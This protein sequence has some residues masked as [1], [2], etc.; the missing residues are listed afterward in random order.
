MRDYTQLNRGA[1]QLGTTVGGGNSI[2][3]QSY[4]DTMA[5]LMANSAREAQTRKNNSDAALNEQRLQNMRS[6][7]DTFLRNATGLNE[8]QY[9][10]LI[11]G[12]RHGW[13][14]KQAEG[15]PTPDGTYPTMEDRPAWATPD[16]INRY[17]TGEMALSAND[18]GTGKTS[19]EQLMGA[20]QDAVNLNRQDAIIN[21]QVDPDKVAA[22]MAAVAGKPTMDVTSSGIA[23]KPYGGT[24][25]INSTAFDRANE[26]K[27]QNKADR[28]RSLT[29][30]QQANNDEIDAARKAI[31]NLSREDVIKRTQQYTATGRENPN[32]DPYLASMVRKATQRKVGND[33]E[34]ESVYQTFFGKG[35]DHADDQ[36]P[37]PDAK[38]APD[39]NWY[40]PDPNRPGK[41]VRVRRVQED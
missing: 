35:S 10:Q 20:M 24:K 27:L 39:G 31:A 14:L 32:Y 5:K 9:D 18:V 26:I 7:R 2:E 30:A 38:K 28:A 11:N 29:P 17:R 40:I 6:G 21:G 1:V 15:P 8:S 36:P 3:Q 23:F 16:V 12:M 4:A 25:D 37:R 41:Y 33:Q 34:F 22:A 13:A 19:A